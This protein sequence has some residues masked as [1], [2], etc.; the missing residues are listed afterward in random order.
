MSDQKIP[1]YTTS[2]SSGINWNS[3]RYRL[4]VWGKNVTN[5]LS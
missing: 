5:K 4:M 2:M 1:G 3:D